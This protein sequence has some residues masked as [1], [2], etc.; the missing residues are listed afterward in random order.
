MPRVIQNNFT[1]GMVTDV[2]GASDSVF[3][4][5][6]MYVRRPSEICTRG[7][8]HENIATTGA[9]D[10][11]V[12]VSVANFHPNFGTGAIRGYS[13]GPGG[14][15][16]SATGFQLVGAGLQPRADS[17]TDTGIDLTVIT[18]EGSYAKTNSVCT[19]NNA[20]TKSW[21]PMERCDQS[22]VSGSE[23]VFAGID[24]R[25]FKWG[26]S[27][28]ASYETGTVS[29]STSTTNATIITGSG[30]NFSSNCEAGQYIL[31]DTVAEKAS[32]EQRAF[33]ITKVHSTTEIEIE[34]PVYLAT[35]NTGLKYKIQ[36]VACISSPDGVWNGTDEFPRT[37][38]VV[39]YWQEK[40][41]VA[42]VSD[43]STDYN[44]VYD[45]DKIRWSGSVS[46]YGTSANSDQFFSHMDLWD[47]DAYLY[48]FAGVGGAIMGLVPMGNSLIVLKA[49]GMFAIT[50][51]N[52]Y[53]ATGGSAYSINMISDV[54][55]AT[56]KKSFAVTK[57]GLVIA[58]TD[59]LYLYNETDGLVCLS[60]ERVARWWE[61]SYK[62]RT[63]TVTATE[64][65]VFVQ[66]WGQDDLTYSPRD[67]PTLVWMIDG[68]YFWEM[69]T[70]D[71][72]SSVVRTFSDDDEWVQDYA[73]LP[74]APTSH[75]VTGKVYY[76][77]ITEINHLKTFDPTDASNIYS[78]TNPEIITH[79]Y[80]LGEDPASEGR[81]N[82]VLIHCLSLDATAGNVVS[83]LPGSTSPHFYLGTTATPE[84][85]STEIDLEYTIPQG[86]TDRAHRIPSDS[87][88]PAVSCRIRID[89][90]S[91]SEPNHYRIYSIG[92]EYEPVNVI[93]PT[94]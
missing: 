76:Y 50:G 5:R 63:F 28:N 56:T 88:D 54:V 27:N 42:G 20:G 93:G 87:M 15:I 3:R 2:T 19:A 7:P 94:A 48:A 65:K 30:T 91:S 24:G 67:A 31:I 23:M 82:N 61:A 73:F 64:D 62:L 33:R 55:G 66:G 34:C 36:S 78:E 85:T 14:E 10:Y 68:D 16:W 72:F 49:H 60:D 17:I 52:N 90:S 69:S 18:E 9:D 40:L 22:C 44:T 25:L 12:G 29:V 75:V 80:P 46:E 13:T 6:D 92:V 11:G 58:A 51:K 45:L 83:L 26:G 53:T 39:A 81:I 1:K 38:G 32:T 59:G 4:L 57:A 70:D 41:W 84:S 77:N 47:R 37:K 86:T 79:A 21:Y 74:A 8:I 71:S 89:A 35:S 43:S